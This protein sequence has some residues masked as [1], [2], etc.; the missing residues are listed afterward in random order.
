MLSVA[1]GPIFAAVPSMSSADPNCRQSTVVRD[2]LA[3]VKRAAPIKEVPEFEDPTFDRLPFAPPGLRLE[4]IKSGLIV[5]SSKV[6]FSLGNPFG[7]RHHLDWIIE[8]ELVKV[9]ARGRDLRSLGVR[10]RGVGTLQDDAAIS[11]LHRV[12]AAPAYYRVDIRFIRKGTGRFLGQ[13]S[14]YVR[15][16][17]PRVD[18]RVKIERP[19]VA[20]REYA[21]ATI[22]NFGTVPLTTRSYDFGFSVQAFTGE[23]W[24]RVPDNPPRKIRKRMGPWVLSAGV[25]DSC[26]LRYLV[27]GDQPSGLFRFIAYGMETKAETLVAEFQVVSSPQLS[28]AGQISR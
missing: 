11:L 4:A 26:R 8:S 17:K 1:L 14:S 28:A 12:S 24:I 23:K 27:P 19:T 5:E 13:Y 16:M 3:Q 25:E 7:S 6:G 2:Y 15:V 9:S 21:R 10:R 18:L 20:P 22:L